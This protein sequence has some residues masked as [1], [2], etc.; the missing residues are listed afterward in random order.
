MIRLS[1]FCQVT[2]NRVFCTTPIPKYSC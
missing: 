1:Y 2:F